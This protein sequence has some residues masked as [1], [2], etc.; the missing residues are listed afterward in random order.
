LPD[1]GAPELRSVSDVVA[2]RGRKICD[3]VGV[4]EYGEATRYSFGGERRADS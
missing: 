4:R 3:M 2:E 1:A